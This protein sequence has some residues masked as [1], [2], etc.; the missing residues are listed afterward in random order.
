MTVKQFSKAVLKIPGTIVDGNVVERTSWTGT[1]PFCC[2]RYISY[3]M[4]PPEDKPTDMVRRSHSTQ[5]RVTFVQMLSP[6]NQSELV[7]FGIIAIYAMSNIDRGEELYASHGTRYT[8]RNATPNTGSQQVL[9]QSK[10]TFSL[11]TY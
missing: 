11:P 6:E 2:R 7:L 9:F 5:S 4:Y 8:F 1:A 3:V 10:S